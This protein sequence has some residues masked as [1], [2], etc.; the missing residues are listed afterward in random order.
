MKRLLQS[1]SLVIL[2]AVLASSAGTASAQDRND[3]N[4]E[5]HQRSNRT[6]TVACESR[7]GRRHRCA[8]DTLGQVTLG[9]QLTRSSNCVEG[10]TWG[11]DSKGIWVDRG[12]R[13]EFLI[14]D[15][16]GTYRERGPSQA[17]R[18]VVCESNGSQRSYCR[19][20]A[21]FGVRLSRQLGRSECVLNRTWGS[22]ANG[23]WVSNG[24]RAEFSFKTRE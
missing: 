20:D 11:S 18:T 7:D 4:R 13:A 24:C 21:H 6:V 3:R 19:G 15:N 2:A 12:C 5:D 9:R 1:S 14:A 23:V 8:A 17:M 10:R 22:D 16:A